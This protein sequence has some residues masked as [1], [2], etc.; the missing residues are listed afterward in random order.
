MFIGNQIKIYI[1]LSLSI[2]VSVPSVF[3]INSSH[4][5][6]E[7]SEGLMRDY[8]EAGGWKVLPGE[9]GRNGIDGLF[10]K[11]DYKGTIIDTLFV[12]SKYGSSQLGKNL[13]CGGNQMS[14]SW[15]KCKVD[16]L[17]RSAQSR[18]DTIQVKKYVQLKS[19][20]VN[21]NYRGLLWKSNVDN[22]KLHVDLQ[23]VHSKGEDVDLKKLVGGEKF[24]LQYSTNTPIDMNNPQNS[25]QRRILDDYYKNLNLSLKRQ[26]VSAN[27]RNA[28]MQKFRSNPQKIAVNLRKYERSIKFKP[29]NL[30]NTNQSNLLKSAS[31]IFDDPKTYTQNETP[32]TIN[33]YKNFDPKGKSI[34]RPGIIYPNGRII[35]AAAES[36]GAGLLVFSTEG[37]SACYKYY[38]GDMLKPEFD[39]EIAGAA[40]KGASVGG[41]IAV[42]VLLGSNPAGWVVMGVGAGS[43]YIAD[44]GYKVW[45]EYKDG[46]YLT[47]KDFES[48]GFEFDPDA[49]FNL[50][51]W[52]KNELFN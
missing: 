45:T 32:K 47:Q 34:I 10:V 26:G 36:V 46:K 23:R 52:G 15:L 40:I 38:N 18:G 25:F 7:A 41:G 35:V 19:H 28:L 21:D 27:E 6:G 22:G 13:V 5:F 20:I 29:K 33:G 48:L 43:Y 1:I 14:K 50:E 51:H 8:F 11:Y 3:A 44:Q 24:K 2:F 30:F 49:P 12:E 4:V 37:G 17:I 42:A 9:V 31:N 16:A 39:R